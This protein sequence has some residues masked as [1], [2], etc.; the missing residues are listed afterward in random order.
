M[1]PLMVELEEPRAPESAF[2]CLEGYPEEAL[3]RYPE[4]RVA[5]ELMWQRTRSPYRVRWVAAGVRRF[6]AD[7]NL[8]QPDA[9]VRQCQEVPTRADAV[10]DSY[11]RFLTEQGHSVGQVSAL[12][13]GPMLWLRANE[14]RVGWTPASALAHKD[15]GANYSLPFP[16]L[17]AR[18]RFVL[19][20][21]T[22]CNLVMSEM[23]ALRLADVGEIEGSAASWRP[24]PEA[25]APAVRVP[26]E[27]A[28]DGQERVT[29][30]SY[31][32]GRA[33]QN[34]LAKRRAAGHA[35]GLDAPL[36]ADAD[37]NP[38]AMDAL[39]DVSKR[40]DSLLRVTRELNVDFCIETGKALRMRRQ[41]HP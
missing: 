38:V 19:T 31:D 11:W 8:G 13:M 24:H 28:K 21:L 27:A 40:M 25:D 10:V 35:L 26:P 5:A 30:L 3:W 2:G 37:G 16:Q 34:Y 22:A 7:L 32:A 29:F 41:Y 18:D 36:L 33:L 4:V 9:F 23:V 15:D 6:L 14:V 39:A 17:N 12:C 20:A 1:R